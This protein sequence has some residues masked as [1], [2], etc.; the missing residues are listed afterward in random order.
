M[1]RLTLRHNVAQFTIDI[2]F[3]VALMTPLV[4]GIIVGNQ[5]TAILLTIGVG[6]G[7]SLHMLQKVLLYEEL[8]SEEVKDHVES[9][10]EQTV[11]ERTEQEVERQV[12][13][14]VAE[15]DDTNEM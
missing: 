15:V 13:Q 14:R 2:L 6:V 9:E 11:P 3:G 5:A 7:Y 8:L 10:V 4:Y 1:K 12:E